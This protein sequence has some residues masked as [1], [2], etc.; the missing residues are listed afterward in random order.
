MQLTMVTEQYRRAA[1][2]G[3][4]TLC[5]GKR[6]EHSDRRSYRSVPRK[7]SSAVR[8]RRA[9]RLGYPG[10]NALGYRALNLTGY[11]VATQPDHPAWNATGSPRLERNRITPVGTRL[12]P[13]GRPNLAGYNA[14]IAFLADC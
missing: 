2:G 1:A 3:V 7:E 10:R 13:P 11:P 8:S 5:G 12:P 4:C 14:Q 9:A 6:T